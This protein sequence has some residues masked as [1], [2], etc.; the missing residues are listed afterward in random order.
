[1]RIYSIIYNEKRNAGPKAPKDIIDI[2]KKEYNAKE[3][4]LIRK[5]IYKIILPL[6]LL[7]S[8]FSNEINIIQYPFVTN[9]KI[10]DFFDLDKSILIIHD[11]KGLRWKNEK[12]LKKEINIFKKF[13]YIVV[14]NNRMKKFL[15]EN[16]IIEENMYVLQLFDYLIDDKKQKV[17]Q[18]IIKSKVKVVYSGNL[19]KEK[20]PFIYQIDPKKINFELNLYGL[21]IENDIASNILYKGSFEPEN[22]N[23]IQGN[24]GLVW[25]GN[26]DE[27]DVDSY[28]K[29]YLKYNNP[30][31]LSC[32]MATGIPVI[33]WSK[34]AI[35]DFIKKNNI[36]YLINNIYDINNIDFSDFT[37]KLKNVKLIR[38]DVLNG[39]YTKSVL[40]NIISR[41]DKDEK[42]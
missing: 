1:M 11:I 40:N 36:G 28:F 7:F 20:S 8:K 26:L 10:Y 21:G 2:V 13:K 30:H 38:N 15:S 31:K 12:L 29:N 24:V 6:K 16:G 23:E 4:T 39:Y 5:G 25:D 27:S 35:S 9:N 41:M 19:S 42:K 37:E 33:A 34:S 17:N 3:I 32:Y 22:V 14:H 18:N